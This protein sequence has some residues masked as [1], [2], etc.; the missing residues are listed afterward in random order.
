MRIFKIDFDKLILLLLPTFERKKG[1]FNFLRV[2]LSP[3][4]SIYKSFLK[5]RITDYYKIEHTGQVNRLENALND[6]FDKE[7]RRIII[8]R[9]NRYERQYIYTSA[10]QRPRYLGT[11]YI[12]TLDEFADTGVDFIILV[13]Q[14]V[15]DAN[16]TIDNVQGKRFYDI[17][18]LVDYYKLASKRYKIELL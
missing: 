11:M 16:I 14:D 5:K 3:V 7:Q 15:W 10:E 1:L 17:E 4:V 2:L 6:S 8:K 9:G 12:R 18:S 13:P